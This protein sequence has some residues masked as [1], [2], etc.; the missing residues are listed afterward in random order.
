VA[1]L[2][3]SLPPRFQ[4]IFDLRTLDLSRSFCRYLNWPQFD[5]GPDLRRVETWPRPEAAV[6]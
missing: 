1:A 4:L 2:G 5:S 6:R 3:T